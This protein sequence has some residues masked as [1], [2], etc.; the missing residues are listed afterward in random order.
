MMYKDDVRTASAPRSGGKTAPSA[1]QCQEFME[2]L[3]NALK[4]MEERYPP[5]KKEASRWQE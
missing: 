2:C 4:I 5:M 3:R 1:P